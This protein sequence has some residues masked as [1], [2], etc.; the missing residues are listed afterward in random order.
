MHKTISSSRREQ[1][2]KDAINE[3]LELFHRRWMLRV[4]WELRDGALTFRALQS[5]CG[6]ISPTVLNQRLAEL[7]EASLVVADDAGYQLT[8]LGAELIVAFA[9]LS[10]WALRWRRYRG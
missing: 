4:L 5:R 1:L 8:E 3:A 9:P 10:A 6:D 2:A 7:R